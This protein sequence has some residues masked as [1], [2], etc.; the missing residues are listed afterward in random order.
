MWFSRKRP[1]RAQRVRRAV[2]E[3]MEQRRLMSVTGLSIDTGDYVPPGAG[4]SN[5]PT[6]SSL[7]ERVDGFTGSYTF[8]TDHDAVDGGLA[9]VTVNYGD[10]VGPVQPQLMSAGTYS[11]SHTYQEK[12]EYDAAVSVQDSSGYSTTTGE[13]WTGTFSSQPAHFSVGDAPLGDLGANPVSFYPNQQWQGN[14]GD[15]GDALD[16]NSD[17][18]IDYGYVNLND[19]SGTI[20][21]GDGTTTAAS[22]GIDQG[23]KI[24]VSGS[25]TYNYQMDPNT[26]DIVHDANT[27]YS[28]PVTM[29]IN[30]SDGASVVMQ[31]MAR[32]ITRPFLVVSTSNLDGAP[33]YKGNPITID[34]LHTAGNKVSFFITAYDTKGVKT[35]IGTTPPTITPGVGDAR[36]FAGNPYVPLVDGNGGPDPCTYEFD[37]TWDPTTVMNGNNKLDFNI[38]LAGFD[39]TTLHITFS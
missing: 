33:D 25:H 22:F 3:T 38:T 27:V 16:R 30:D 9:Y 11:F 37:V 39:S 24:A 1:A 14:L 12:G 13:A 4:D 21:W 5:G 36:A 6:P 19:Y 35:V 29:N 18:G 8:H 31:T 7:T 28:Y 15:F 23:G 34:H 10:F 17:G 20:N 32:V 2:V 26:G